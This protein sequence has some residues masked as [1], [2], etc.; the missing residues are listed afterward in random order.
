[1]VSSLIRDGLV[2]TVDSQRYTVRVVFPDRDNM[3]SGELPLVA[4]PGLHRLPN[5]GDNVLCLFLGN[6]ISKGYCLGQFFA[7]NEDTPAV[8]P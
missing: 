2:S 6:G 8:I 4:P 1:M 5:V 3:V 7:D